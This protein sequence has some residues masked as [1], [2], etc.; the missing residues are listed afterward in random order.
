MVLYW[1]KGWRS[2]RYI[3]VIE[4]MGICVMITNIN[5]CIYH[6]WLD[7]Q[8]YHCG[9]S[10]VIHMSDTPH[11]TSMALRAPQAP[12]KK[13]GSETCLI[14]LKTVIDT[15]AGLHADKLSRLRQEDGCS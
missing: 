3:I 11:H 2:R 8:F 9:T 15:V 13:E 14:F 10:K 4:A 6:G 1:R 12:E 7:M 5:F